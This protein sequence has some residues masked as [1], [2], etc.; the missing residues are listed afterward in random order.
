MS[1]R[2]LASAPSHCLS[3]DPD[4]CPPSH[5]LVPFTPACPAAP[6]AIP[7]HA[8]GSAFCSRHRKPHDESP[9]AGLPKTPC[10]LWATLL[11][12]HLWSSPCCPWNTAAGFPWQFLGRSGLH[13][14][15][16][17]PRYLA[18]QHSA[19]TSLPKQQRQGLRPQLCGT[20]SAKPFT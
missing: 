15:H 9:Q 2:V 10:W 5:A 6:A 17:A 18:G 4:T 7:S 13:L 16:R 19:C 3:P 12:P 1:L 14:Q 8:R 20:A 11:C